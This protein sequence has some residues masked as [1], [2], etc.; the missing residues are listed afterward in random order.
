[1]ADLVDKDIIF[2]VVL[3]EPSPLLA[4]TPFFFLEGFWKLRSKCFSKGEVPTLAR[5]FL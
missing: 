1:L 5:S 2:I 4:F 3:D